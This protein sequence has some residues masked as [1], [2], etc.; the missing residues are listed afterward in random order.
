MPYI[1][2]LNHVC[3]YDEMSLFSGNFEVSTS[4]LLNWTHNHSAK[5]EITCLYWYSLYILLSS[6]LYSPFYPLTPYLPKVHSHVHAFYRFSTITLWSI[7]LIFLRNTSRSLILLQASVTP[8]LNMLYSQ[9][10]PDIIPLK[11]TS[12]AVV[13]PNS[14]PELVRIFFS[15][16]LSILKTW[17]LQWDITSLLALPL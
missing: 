9:L 4:F 13:S 15:K 10:I 17:T 1:F 2:K 16:F 7:L 3:K 11:N 5:A 6:L 14:Y 12:A 8:P